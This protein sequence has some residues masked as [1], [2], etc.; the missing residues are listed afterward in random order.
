M[1]KQKYLKYKK[2]YLDLANNLKGGMRDPNSIKKERKEAQC[3]TCNGSGKVVGIEQTGTDEDGNP[4]YE[5]VLKTCGT[6]LGTGKIH[7]SVV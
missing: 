7:G 3:P 1:Y 4:I 5:R 6:C 2:K